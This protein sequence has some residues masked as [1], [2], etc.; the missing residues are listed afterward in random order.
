MQS[1][2]DAYM[3]IKTSQAKTYMHKTEQFVTLGYHGCS[4]AY[5]NNASIQNSQKGAYRSWMPAHVF[6]Q[7]EQ[8]PG[9]ASEF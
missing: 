4:P 5:C 7:L 6:F 9:P 8:S 1:A 2:D 3:L